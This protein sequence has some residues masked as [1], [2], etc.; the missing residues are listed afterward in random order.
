[1]QA[2]AWQPFETSDFRLSL[3][4]DMGLIIAW[5]Q[6]AAREDLKRVELDIE[7]CR[8]LPEP[9]W[10]QAG[11]DGLRIASGLEG[12]EGQVWR[13][14]ALQAS[15]WW[16]QMPTSNEW[17]LFVHAGAAA[18]ELPLL[19]DVPQ[20]EA[21]AW[22]D[23]AWAPSYGMY[24][25]AGHEAGLQTKVL[26]IAGVG[27]LVCAGAVF[28]QAWDVHSSIV[29]R[30]SEIAD[31]NLAAKTVL[32]SRDQA[33]ANAAQ[34]QLLANWL[35]EP[36]PIEVLLHLNE[37]LGKS[38][39]MIKEMDLAGRKLRLG[40]QLAPQASRAAVVKDLQSGDWFKSVAEI[41]T[42]SAR[43]MM[44]VEMNLDGLRAPAKR[45]SPPLPANDNPFA[46]GGGKS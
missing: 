23:K 26:A 37:V 14:G 36:L 15:R 44:V 20:A 3:L 29:Q 39:A 41:R 27:I 25:G 32:A 42:D 9:L 31:L 34:A 40:L 8:L 12:M 43:G 45:A 19:T 46:T 38:G 5:D 28:R 24:E 33:L 2:Q 1:M 17:Q 7:R 21:V 4:G 18:D 35:T 6:A 13:A 22:S 11:S 10:R 16:P 30:E